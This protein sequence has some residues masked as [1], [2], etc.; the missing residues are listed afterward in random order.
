[1]EKIK[2]RI[3]ATASLH[4]LFNDGSVVVLPTIFPILLKETE[5]LNDYSGIG[6]MMMIGLFVAV[7]FQL[8]LGHSARR[9]HSR[10]YLAADALL[11]GI[12]LLL[13]TLARSYLML[14]LFFLGVR[15][16]T[17]I[18]HPVGIAW[19]SHTFRGKNLD[20]AMGV[21]SAS[22]NV[23]VLIAFTTTGLL[24]HY[25]GWKAPLYGWGVFNLLAVA[26]GLALSRGAIERDAAE[27][28]REK[29]SWRETFGTVGRFVPM[30]LLSGTCWGISVNYA[31]SLLNRGLGISMDRTGVILGFWMAAGTAAAFFYGHV[32][33]KLNRTRTI[34]LAY[35]VML[36]SSLVLGRSENAPLTTAAF[37]IYG[38]ALFT[39]YPAN[40]SFVGNTVKGKNRTAAFSLVSNI[41]IIGN[42]TF[43]FIAGRMSDRFGI[44]SPFL[45]ISAFSFALIAYVAIMKRNGGI[46]SGDSA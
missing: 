39:T 40:L 8:L 37:I 24:V 13:M 1:M 2:K 6:D 11:V 36:I 35:S 33:G 18:Y 25:F 43:S 44:H 45:L 16:G 14:V 34:I 28:P 10:Y 20:R 15:M 29:V 5:L 32:S 27:A 30:I 9:H 38:T 42:S 12:F 23:G 46:G 22:G 21:Q 41:M 17:S 31:S 3:M 7:G 19:I 26:G 4:H